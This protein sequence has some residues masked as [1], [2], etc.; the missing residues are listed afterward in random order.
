MIDASANNPDARHLALFEQAF[1]VKGKEW[2]YEGE[3][4]HFVP[5]D[6]C[7]KSNGLYF[8]PFGGN[9]LKRWS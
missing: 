3:Y 2:A 5:L 9:K 7:Q 8:F 1:N 6:R 4:R